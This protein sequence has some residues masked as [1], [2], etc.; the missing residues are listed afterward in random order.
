M[1]TLNEFK[2]YKHEVFDP[3]IRAHV[4]RRWRSMAVVGEDLEELSDSVARRI[5][6]DIN[7]NIINVV[8]NHN[9]FPDFQPDIDKSYQHLLKEDDINRKALKALVKFVDEDENLTRAEVKKI[10]DDCIGFVKAVVN[11]REFYNSV[12]AENEQLKFTKRVKF[13]DRKGK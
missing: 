11:S 4:T 12:T 6:D 8:Y 5:N 2:E 10:V 3:I 9:E 7:P 13:Y 1:P